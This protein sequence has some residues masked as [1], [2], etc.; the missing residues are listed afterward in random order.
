MWGSK[1]GLEGRG[2]LCEGALDRVPP[3]DLDGSPT[4]CFVNNGRTSFRL[5]IHGHTALV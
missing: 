3:W 5:Q 2:G 1:E 4:G